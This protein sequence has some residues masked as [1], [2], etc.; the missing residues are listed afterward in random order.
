MMLIRDC[1]V[2]SLTRS[3]QQVEGEEEEERREEPGSWDVE[4]RERWKAAFE[5]RGNVNRRGVL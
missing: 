2:P 5:G 4:Q 1:N 3:E